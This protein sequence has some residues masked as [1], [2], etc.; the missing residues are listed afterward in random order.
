MNI[1]PDEARVALDTIER[2]KSKARSVRN[3]QTYIA[4]LWSVIWI[5]GFLAS[6][7]LPQWISWI[8]GVLDSIGIVG[9]VLLDFLRRRKIR[10][11]PGSWAATIETRVGTLYNV[12]F[13][14]AIFG[15]IVFRLTAIQAAMM[16]VV[17]MMVAFI[18][19]GVWFREWVSSCVGVGVILMSVVGY[20]LF[21]S[22]FWLW[23]AIFAGV[24]V[25]V[26]AIYYL[27]RI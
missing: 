22:I 13:G 2:A 15:L 1:T 12:L 17:V 9:F 26:L 16:W 8:W 14:L 7:L 6:Q 27:R 25:F 5:V 10:L 11:A 23:E 4:L 20:A 3:F 18:I 24:P 19:I 21:P